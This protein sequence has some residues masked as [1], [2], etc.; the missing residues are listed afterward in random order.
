MGLFLFMSC[1]VHALIWISENVSAL[2]APQRIL[3]AVLDH[4]WSNHKV[5][6]IHGEPLKQRL[7]PNFVNREAKMLHSLVLCINL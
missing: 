7:V 6:R 5:S 1:F 3:R 4:F 2:L